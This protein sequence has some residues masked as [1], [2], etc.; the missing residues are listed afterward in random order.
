MG[1]RQLERAG[2]RAGQHAPGGWS[3][4]SDAWDV[5]QYGGMH[6]TTIHLDEELEAQLRAESRRTGKSMAALIREALRAR[7]GGRPL[8]TSRHAGAFSSA[9][10]DTAEDV[11]QALRD[12]GFGQG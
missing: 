7:F 4:Q 1:I 2:S 12:T 9:R 10:H 6:R 3:S 8:P 5:W 11:D